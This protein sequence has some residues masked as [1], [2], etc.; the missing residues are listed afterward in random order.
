M[1]P[2][3]VFS[4]TPGRTLVVREAPDAD[5]VDPASAKRIGAA[6]A[7]G[8]GHGLLVVFMQAYLTPAH[9]FRRSLL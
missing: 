7:R 5:H 4:L 9:Q 3:L 1:A 8:V 2:G 6:F